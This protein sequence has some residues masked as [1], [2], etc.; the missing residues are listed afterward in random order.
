MISSA[1][2]FPVY[3]AL[4]ATHLIAILAGDSLNWMVMA[5]KPL[6]L[7][8]LIAIFYMH[9]A[10]AAS[11]FRMLVLAALIFSWMGDVLLLFQQ[12]QTVL[13]LAGLVSF[14]L[15]HVCYILVFRK[16]SVYHSGSVIK[17]KP[18][19]ILVF[20]IYGAGFYLLIRE[21][22]GDLKI[23]VMLY[24]AV[25]LLM[26]LMASN[27]FRRVELSS[28]LLVLAGAICFVASDSL[29]ALN[30]FVA[31]FPFSSFLIMLTYLA[32]QYLI[33]KGLLVQVN[34]ERLDKL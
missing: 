7:L 5:T 12:Q 28:F 17:D 4:A 19:L 31:A 2:S 13:F 26:S 27:R 21:G 1:F 10:T 8:S 25:I 18:W 34:S 9:S 24:M 22:L 6:L 30:K 20:I 16:T 3:F 14:L 29:L 11:R 32:A 33:V 15:A 23:P